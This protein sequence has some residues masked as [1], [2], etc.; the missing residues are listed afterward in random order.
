MCD[1][2]GGARGSEQLLSFGATPQLGSNS[3]CFGSV[4]AAPSQVNW[5]VAELMLV[6][7][8]AVVAFGRNLHC[9][10]RVSPRGMP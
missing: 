9:G 7:V 4:G 5:A 10:H 2:V 6:A 3:Y 1:N 8:V